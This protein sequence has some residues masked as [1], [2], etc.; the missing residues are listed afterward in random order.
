MLCGALGKYDNQPVRSKAM[1]LNFP[2]SVFVSLS[3]GVSN[4]ASASDFLSGTIEVVRPDNYDVGGFFIRVS[5]A[6]SGTPTCS[7]P[8]GGA[9]N[10]YFVTKNNALMKELLS[11]ALSAK[12]T[13]KNVTIVG[14]GVCTQGY[15]D[16]RYIQIN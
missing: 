4:V 13:E 10:W 14:K 1:K 16:I 5:G 8:D 7:S 15:E 12:L 3:L 2:A 11:V 6:I 9:Y